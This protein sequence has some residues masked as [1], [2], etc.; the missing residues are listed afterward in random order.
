MDGPNDLVRESARSAEN[1]AQQSAD[2]A[3]TP[4]RAQLALAIAELARAGVELAEAQEPALRLGAVIA[5]AARREAEI[6]ALRAADEARLGAWIAGGGADPRPEPDPVTI[7]AEE[8]R[9]ALAAG[10]IAAGS[11]LPAA[12][13][14]FQRCAERVR[15]LQRRR[16]AAL[17]GAAIDAARGFAE[18]YRAA[19]T[20]ALEHEG[21]LRG[22]REE[23]LAR[24]NRSESEP[25][26]IDAAARI[27]ELIAETKRGVAVRCNPQTARRLL[28]ALLSDPDASL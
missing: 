18:R 3:R 13:R 5:E 16:D 4:P 2:A 14:A 19:L 27:G 7:A 20:A 6:A 1:A 11:A 15:E 26:A 17:C 28:A 10:A 21:V 9:A 12:E 8:R 22:L 23:L 24:G 25:G